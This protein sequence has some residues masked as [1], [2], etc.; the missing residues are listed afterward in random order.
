MRSLKC[1]S[2]L[3]QALQEGANALIELES[4]KARVGEHP[5]MAFTYKANLRQRLA[6]V[7]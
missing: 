3:Q 7:T 5:V 6:R 2:N 1:K 4:P